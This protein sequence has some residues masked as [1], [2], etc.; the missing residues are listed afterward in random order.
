MALTKCAF[1]MNMILHGVYMVAKQGVTR[2]LGF[3]V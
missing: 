1:E 2:T 3:R